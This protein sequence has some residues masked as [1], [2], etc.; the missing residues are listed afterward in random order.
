MHVRADSTVG[1]ER[2]SSR[3]GVVLIDL[4]EVIVARRPP[5]AINH[6]A[7]SSFLERSRAAPQLSSDG[8]A[9]P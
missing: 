8:E 9:T 1:C 5:V 4:A 3:R 7:I 6:E 2:D